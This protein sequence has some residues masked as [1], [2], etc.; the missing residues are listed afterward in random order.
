MF[1]IARSTVAGGVAISSIANM[2]V[3]PYVAMIIGLVRLYN[4]ANLF[5]LSNTVLVGGYGLRHGS[6]IRAKQ[7]E[8]FPS[9]AHLIV[10]TF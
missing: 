8:C 10:T 6:S 2:L 5:H 1:D 3:S 9:S 7:S 4:P